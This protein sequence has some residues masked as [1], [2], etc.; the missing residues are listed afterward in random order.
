MDSVS[1]RIGFVM[2]KLTVLMA[3]TKQKH[4]NQNVFRCFTFD[5]KMESASTECGD[6][7][8]KMIAVIAPMKK[9]VVK[10]VVN[11]HVQLANGNALV[12]TNASRLIRFA[13]S[14][15]TA[16]MAPT[17]ARVVWMLTALKA[18]VNMAADRHPLASRFATISM[19]VPMLFPNATR[20]ASIPLEAINATAQEDKMPP[21]LVFADIKEI[22]RFE[23]T[24]GNYDVL[25]NNLTRIVALDFDV[26]TGTIFFTDVTEN[27]IYK[28]HYTNTSTGAS[29]PKPILTTGLAVPDGIAFDW[30]A[31]NIYF[32]ESAG[33][34]IDIC[35]ANGSFRSPLISSGVDSPRGIAL[36][37]RDG[38]MFFSDWGPNAHIERAGMDGTARKTLAT[39][40]IGWPNGLTVDYTTRTIYWADARLDYIG[41]IDYHGKNRRT[42][43]NRVRHPFAITS[44]DEYVYYS[45]WTHRGILRIKKSP[46]AEHPVIVVSNLSR[47]MDLHVYHISRQPPA[48]NPCAVNNG[49]CQQL[50]VISARN[51]SSCLCQ[52]GYEI[53]ADNRTCSPM[54]QF[55]LF[56]RSAEL[57]GISLHLH[58]N[59]QHDAMVPVLGLSNIVGADFDAKE[60]Q[61]YFTDV[62]LGKIGRAP[63]DGK[64]GPQF[65][66]SENLQNPDGISVDWIGR[67]IYWTD[68]KVQGK[69]EI[70][71]SRL[72]GKYRKSLITSGLGS[73]RAITV[74]PVAGYLFYTDW[75]QPAK[76]G[77]ADMDGSH[78]IILINGTRIGWPN[79]LA[80]DFNESKIYWA[81]AKTDVIERMNLNGLAR[82]VVLTGLSHPFGLALFG[83]FIFFSDWQDRSIFRVSKHNTSSFHVLRQGLVGLMELQVY[84]ESMQTGN[85]SC[86]KNTC[87]QLCLARP[88]GFTCACENNFT[89]ATDNV[90]CIASGT[91]K[92]F[93]CEANMFKCADGNCIRERWRCDGDADCKD[94]SDETEQTC[95]SV[96][97]DPSS[98]LCGTNRCIPSSWRCDRESDC[99]DAS[100]EKNCTQKHRNCT[101]LQF[102]CANDKCIQK[103]WHCDGDND[104]GDWSDE[105]SCGNRTCAENQFAC[106]NSRCISKTWRCDGEADCPD[107]TDEKGCTP[108]DCPKLG[109]FTC[110]NSKCIQKKFRC[111][112]D[113]DCG[114]GSDEKNCGICDH[115]NCGLCRNETE[116]KCSNGRCINKEFVCDFYND[117]GDQ[118]D[119]EA[120]CNN[121]TCD[122]TKQIRCGNGRCLPVDF[123]CDGSNDCGD[124][125]DEDGCEEKPKEK[126]CAVN[127]EWRCENTTTC[128][129]LKQLC[130]GKRDCPNGLD[131]GPGCKLH[132]CRVFN[133]GCSHQCFASPN[134]V[135]CGCPSGMKLGND[136]K[137]CEDIN[138]C[139]TPGMCSQKC[140]NIKR[141]Y[142]CFCEK[143]YILRGNKKTCSAIGEVP[144]LVYSD[145]REIRQYNL[146]TTDGS[147]IVSGLTNAIGLDFDWKEQAIYWS[148]VNDD[149]IEKIHFNGSNRRV[150]VDTGLLAP[151][152]IAVD[153]IGRNLYWSDTK[154]DTID[155]AKLDGS[156][157]SNIIGSDLEAPRAI[158]VDPRDGYLFWTDWGKKPRVERANMDGT[159]RIALVSTKLVWPNGLTVD[160]ANRL[161]FFIDARVDYLQR[162]KYDGTERIT[163]LQNSIIKH[164]FAV[165]NFE[166]FLYFSDWNPPASILRVNKYRGDSKMFIQQRLNKP[167]G[168][169]VAHPVMQQDAVNY[170]HGHN[171]SHLCVL[172]PNGYSCKCPFGM[173]LQSD[174]RFCKEI[175]AVLL[176][177]RRIEIRGISTEK[178]DSVDKITPITK[179]TNA[180][181]IDFDAAT[182]HIYWSDVN[183]DAIYRIHK[184]GTGRENIVSGV[185]SAVDIAVDWIANNLY[186]TDSR[187]DQI[188]VSRLNGIYRRVIISK[189]LDEPRGIAV[190]PQ[191]GKLFWSDWGRPS[192]IESSS[193]DGSNRSVIVSKNI[194]TPNGITLDLKREV[195]YWCDALYDRIEALYL[196]NMSRVV[197]TTKSVMVSHPFG[198]TNFGDYLFWTDWGRRG[199][200]R[201]NV[202]SKEIITIK[203]GISSLMGTEVFDESRQQ[204]TNPCENGNNG[205]QH[206]C[207]FLGNQTRCACASGF[208]L[209]EDSK[210]C[211]GSKS[212]LIYTASTEVRGIFFDPKEETQAIVPITGLTLSYAIDYY[213]KD[214]EI[215]II[216]NGRDHLIKSKTDG[217]G[218]EVIIDSGLENPQGVA[219][220]WAAKNVFIADAGRDLI[221]VCRF[222][223]SHRFVV[224]HEGLNSPRGLV[225]Y[226][227][228]GYLYWTDWGHK[229]PKIE[230]SLMDGT[231][232]T[233]LV[234]NTSLTS[235]GWPNGLTID[236]QRNQIY[237]TDAQANALFRMN[238][239]GGDLL[240]LDIGRTVSHPYA[241]SVFG[242]FIYWTEWSPLAIMRTRVSNLSDVEAM[243]SK[244]SN[245]GDIHVFVEERQAGNSSCSV[246]N[247]DCEQLCLSTSN[248]TRRCICT[249]GKLDKDM[250]S[251]IPVS[252]FLFFAKRNEIITLGLEKSGTLA[253]PHK[254]IKAFSN[255]IGVDFHYKTQRIFY[256]DIFTNQ[257]GMIFLNGTGQVVLASDLRTP[258]GIAYDW[259]NDSIYWTDAQE[260]TIS[261]I[262]MTGNLT[263]EILITKDL[264]E[265][266]AITVSPCDGLL[267][268]SDWGKKP[269]I[270]RTTLDGIKMETVIDSGLGW[271][272][273][274][275][276]DYAE[277][278]IFWADA[279]V[280][281]IES[282]NLDGSDRRVVVSGTPHV[283]GISLLGP[284]IYWTDWVARSVKRA[285]KYNGGNPINLLEG[286]DAQPMDIKVFSRQRQNC[287]FSPCFD[288]GPCSHA[289]TVKQ[290][291]WACLCPTNMKLL[292]KVRC[293][294]ASSNCSSSM[295]TCESGQC[296]D[297]SFVCD[298]DP[299]D[300]KDSSDENAKLC[301][302]HKCPKGLFTC[303]STGQCIPKNWQC[304]HDPDCKDGSDEDNCDHPS[305]GPEFFRCGNGRCI[306]KKFVCDGEK[307]CP[308]LSDEK[309]CNRSTCPPGSLKCDTSPSCV[310]KEWI[311]D[312]DNDCLDGSDESKMCSNVSCGAG[313]FACKT[314]RC[315]PDTWY[316]DGDKDCS[317]GSDEPAGT[318]ISKRLICDG[319]FD[320]KDK[321]DEDPKVHR[322]GNR[323][324]DPSEFTCKGNGKCIP[325]R[326]KCD[327]D[328]DCGDAS[329][330][331]HSEGCTV[332]ACTAK[333]FKCD[334]DLCVS[335][336]YLCDDE[337][338]CGDGSD[339]RNCSTCTGKN[340][341]CENGECID[342]KRKCDG[343]KD[344]KDGSDESSTTCS[345]TP[346][347]GCKS[348]QFSCEDGKTC[349]PKQKVCDKK[350]DCPNARDEKGCHINNCLD[351]TLNTCS[352]ICIDT[353]TSYKCSCKRGYKLASDQRTCMDIDECK[354]YKISGCSQICLNT[355][356]SYKCLCR[357]GFLWDSVLK[358][359]KVGSGYARTKL[360]FS[361]E[362]LIGSIS[363]DKR[364]RM[365]LQRGQ[366]SVSSIDILVRNS[367]YFWVNSDTPDLRK[368]SLNQVGKSEPVSSSQLKGPRSLA[369]D[370]VGNNIF[371][372]DT[373]L[374]AIFV[375]KS[376][377]KFLKQLFID[378][379]NHPVLLAICP[380]AGWLYY[381][382]EKSSP[383]IS[384]I[385]LNGDGF[386]RIIKKNIPSPRGLTVDH[387]SKKIYWSD[388][389]LRKIEYAN[390]D[391]SGRQSLFSKLVS[392]PFALTVFGD[393]IFWVDHRDAINKA[394]KLSGKFRQIVTTDYPRLTDIKIIHELTQP[395][396]N[397]T[398][399]VKNGGCSH[400]CLQTPEG[401]HKCECSNNY[402]LAADRKTCLSNCSNG[403]FECANARCI[404]RAWR[405]DTEDDCGD[406]SDEDSTCPERKCRPGQFQCNNFNCTSPY[407][408]CD[409]EDDCGDNSDEQNCEARPCFFFQYRCKNNR[410][411]FENR[412]C[413]GVNDC[414]DGSDERNCSVSKASCS[415]DK[416][417]CRNG[418]CISKVW[419]C[420]GENDC[421][422][423]SDEDKAL[424]AAIKCSDD[425]F[426]C[427][428]SRCILN[429]YLC[430]GDNDCHDG[431][432]ESRLQCSS[433]KCRT[434]QFQC[435]NHRCIPSKWKCDFGN[436]C[437]DNSD[438]QDCPTK[439]CDPKTDF[440]CDNNRCINKKWT[441]D[442]DDDCGDGSDEKLCTNKTCHEVQFT[443]KSGHCISKTWR[444]DG[445]PDCRDG[446]DEIGCSSNA[447]KCRADQ[448]RCK[449]NLCIKNTWLC[450]GENDCLDGSDE[451]KD[452]CKEKDLC[453]R[454][455][456]FRCGDGMCIR[457]WKACDGIKHCSDGSDE[458]NCPTCKNNEFKCHNH[459]CISKKSI[460]DGAVDCKGAEDERWCNK[461]NASCNENNGGC[462][463]GCIQLK[464]GH[465]C[466]CKLGHVIGM[467]GKDCVDINECDTPGSCSQ[468][469]RNEVG[470]FKCFCRK[471][472]SK[473]PGSGQTCKAD[474]NPPIVVLPVEGELR[475]FSPAAKGEYIYEMFL[476]TTSKINCLDFHIKQKLLVVGLRHEK[477]LKV[478]SLSGSEFGKFNERKR[479]DVNKMKMKSI[480]N[481]TGVEPMSIA[482]DWIGN[483]IY[484]IDKSFSPP[485]IMMADLKGQNVRKIITKNIFSPESIALDPENG[486]IY[487]SDARVQP[488]IW[489]AEL[490]GNNAK[491]FVTDQ[492]E[493][494]A[495]LALDLPARRLYWADTK[496]KL[497]SSITLDGKQRTVVYSGKGKSIDYPYSI[498]LFEDYVF[499]LTY[500]SRILFKVHKFGKQKPIVIAK[501]LQVAVHPNL[502]ILQ[503]QKQSLPAGFVNP[504]NRNPCKQLCVVIKGK[505]RCVCSPAKLQNDANCQ[506]I[507]DQ[508]CKS[509][510]C[511]NQGTCKQT[512]NEITCT[513][514]DGY[515]G[516]RCEISVC[517]NYCQNGGTCSATGTTPSCRCRAS[518]SGTRCEVRMT[519]ACTLKCDNNGSCV[520]K[521]GVQ[522]CSC[523]SGFTGKN[524]E[525]ADSCSNK[526]CP[527][528]STCQLNKLKGPICICMPGF[529]KSNAGSCQD[530]CISYKINC[531]DGEK[532]ERESDGRPFCRPEKKVPISVKPPQPRTG[533]SNKL[534]IALPIIIII[535]LILVVVLVIYRRKC[536]SY[537]FKPKTT[538]NIK[539]QNPAFGYSGLLEDGEQDNFLLEEG[540]GSNNFANPLYEKM[541]EKRQSMKS[542]DSYDE[543]TDDQSEMNDFSEKRKLVFDD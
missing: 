256:S 434:D 93:Q 329:D 182:G 19:N 89:L 201:M 17:K 535:L 365:F 400:F 216:D 435:T 26:R 144:L 72:D 342:I 509:S 351:P 51:Q 491:K 212:F 504:C 474:G 540:K 16:E 28:T 37:P 128:I 176:Y 267:Y 471:G 443:C 272:N 92:E 152:G 98:F 86:G 131:E 332:R 498:S 100:D 138:E 412:V 350:V 316:C 247:G 319:D 508:T 58:D 35:T 25:V 403:E 115:G 30:V 408:V 96:T 324:C 157:R 249:N 431:S 495:G 224:I 118:S 232:R 166:D 184:N 159:G 343:K 346:T 75:S 297:R 382:V 353:P 310:R 95:K 110:G 339:E 117:C 127:N 529:V 202:Q 330:E 536:S 322:C 291:T 90:S 260:N 80:I 282:A 447:T 406:G 418:R 388:S 52:Y 39:Y 191:K 109:K 494:P 367:T 513:C 299:F 269:Y 523:K 512:G 444:C 280:D 114:D 363:L 79:G 514:E 38:Y 487:W 251:C 237:W 289:C 24:T 255:V 189:G 337:N 6:V 446:S 199:I 270:K 204:G 416:F 241:I 119:E 240:K 499:G 507:I 534:K 429:T 123:K 84:D 488:A 355:V 379:E 225:V 154:A 4:A 326:Y 294:A 288:N 377:S 458:K 358:S 236:F 229:D 437:G 13:T 99:D 217:S 281:R 183:K 368:S 149:K 340:F 537:L 533:N 136:S 268:W 384:R 81:D 305:C 345:T 20:F 194:G 366:K 331:T 239:D 222:D 97:C 245:V 45:D 518:F 295:F 7:M 21:E 173:E 411:I 134:G 34:R 208:T 432:D 317:D 526:L 158:A 441:C 417:Q 107:A 420:D 143:G 188:E 407:W 161:V 538:L 223:G 479:R 170:C 277:S 522:Q 501:N 263:R 137:I 476:P 165:T 438:E 169:K 221:E 341:K 357:K 424:C 360:L 313:K 395:R 478:Y 442:Q 352:Q 88:H 32:A 287:S 57:R 258:D 274:L 468:I 141:S 483:N 227:S 1:E 113:D 393:K 56:A 54:N 253:P 292:N 475:R 49:G 78:H 524:C 489:R 162:V 106:D 5:V 74:H 215:F 359:C 66:V 130:D 325:L 309:N 151:E 510:I 371:F 405:C 452:T 83:E 271:P 334:N 296:I 111:D 433:H 517:A 421:G 413:N 462:G 65:I 192:K 178:V 492:L 349:I 473:D 179:L 303:K 314:G 64:T 455:I 464:N 132:L 470:S 410:C 327:G 126:S 177:A 180:V 347:S 515:S 336:L 278:R 390:F 315:I 439:S 196:N 308:D 333:E 541:N 427:N 174:Q 12:R 168:L 448:F 248:V 31:K 404:P 454:K 301:R 502:A 392:A 472:Y 116:F 120:S 257:I 527:A 266:R 73:P 76:I 104:C 304:D 422:D 147:S 82:E 42:V 163:I 415:T 493:Y 490:D 207:F 486:Y 264:D 142:K 361:T 414:K 450:D 500:T 273:G 312:G 230:R 419:K 167:M 460:C 23:L 457:K 293:V 300:C 44:Y 284:Y 328:N 375:L 338:D 60:R 430:D 91:E 122:A 477:K 484:W 8:V 520:M 466:Q 195:L 445:E 85:N 55:L 103:R 440:R 321:S 354:D 234:N 198:I 164:P 29:R 146:K 453:D 153:W 279:R 482:V 378:H 22:R 213:Y 436:D 210:S 18:T 456:Q 318:C 246:N 481:V 50:C 139:L 298:G 373:T 47:P 398:C 385:G 519:P 156:L 242:D 129:H 226:P 233:V 33:N 125:S 250:K 528:N 320:C 214:R 262:D 155:A 276:L 68:A 53:Q 197:L 160:Y 465:V 9:I 62:K 209:A 200:V 148:D 467:N 302:R 461:G 275:S 505:A 218:L 543:I 364:S 11:L 61:I 397:S 370:W 27:R 87:S 259:I 112:G 15:T 451:N 306:V 286:L 480:A 449:N 46:T 244:I 135:A 206:L 77:R 311:C 193:L 105:V 459:K 203:E 211:V 423:N 356:G 175:K 231:Q 40:Q 14:K 394:H 463:H 290:N 190:H 185:P 402:R 409:G 307:D 521:S 41:A 254:P 516:R 108:Q 506:P 426:R 124:N 374:H 219:V 283:F 401:G 252:D 243:R 140:V 205:C 503:D 10:L 386:S 235:I 69:P 542:E 396:V 2:V 376:G 265:P 70:G 369:V 425:H 323:T 372:S 48:L 172:K 59:M 67:N 102:A 525:I 348:D 530:V 497:I 133:G 186:W 362:S 383:G 3:A 389:H 532:C 171:C 145:R 399:N 496:Q 387:W 150:V 511:N 381:T 187:K 539:V 285:G 71:V 101:A 531:K 428:N 94:G 238:L 469:C 63:T 261:R 380:E 181:G 344:C 228:K 43:A 36:D 335:L 121:I 391:G 220:D 485:N